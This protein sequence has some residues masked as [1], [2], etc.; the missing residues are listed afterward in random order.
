MLREDLTTI[1]LGSAVITRALRL[2]LINVY[3]I[4]NANQLVLDKAA[5]A[6]IDEVFA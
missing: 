2:T 3:D 1:S 6:K 4:L 5:L